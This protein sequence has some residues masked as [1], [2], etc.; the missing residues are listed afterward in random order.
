MGTEGARRSTG[1]TG[2]PFAFST[3]WPISPTSDDTL[4]SIGVRGS[5]E[6]TP[7]LHTQLCGGA[8]HLRIVRW[9]EVSC[10]RGGEGA[11][12]KSKVH[13]VI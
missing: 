11:Q 7:G 6:I 3:R 10:D 9:V 2:A 1:T 8:R 12:V 13:E 5:V 4:P